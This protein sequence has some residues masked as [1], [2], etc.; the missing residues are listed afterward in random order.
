MRT[1]SGR[2][3]VEVSTAAAL[4]K[5]SQALRRPKRGDPPH[6]VSSSSRNVSGS[7]FINRRMLGKRKVSSISSSVS[8]IG[9]QNRLPAPSEQ[10]LQQSLHAT[11]ENVATLDSKGQ[12]A[13]WGDSNLRTPSQTRGW[14]SNGELLQQYLALAQQQQ[15]QEAMLVE[16]ARQELHRKLFIEV[17]ARRLVQ[18]EQQQMQ[19][20]YQLQSQQSRDLQQQAILQ[21]LQQ[22]QHQLGQISFQNSSILA[23]TQIQPS[24]F[25]T[26]SLQQQEPE[27]QN[28][29]VEDDELEIRH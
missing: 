2:H 9:E 4:E 19:A 6:P 5:V 10:E 18:Q 29:A 23:A 14:Q 20:L 15:L 28:H 24:L 8:S 1:D 13:H 11:S 21:L 16:E 7:P 22:H 26:A 12:V 3:W 17:M 25:P 27:Q